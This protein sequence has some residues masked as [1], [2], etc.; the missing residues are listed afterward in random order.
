MLL[1]MMLGPGVVRVGIMLFVLATLFGA[2]T[3]HHA[4]FSAA[5]FTVAI[6]LVLGRIEGTPFHIGWLRVL[7][8]LLGS[9]VAFAVGA[10]IW[11]VHAREGLRLK[12]ANILDGSADSTAQ[13]PQPPCRE[14]T[15]SSRFANSTASCTTCAGALLSKWTKPATS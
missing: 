13:S 8:T 6:V 2:L 14:S 9:F 12:L 15:T 11:P 4:S 7:Y 5:G 3:V 10:L 1:F